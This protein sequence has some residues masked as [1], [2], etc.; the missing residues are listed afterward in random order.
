[1]D[2]G[3]EAWEILGCINGGG[4]RGADSDRTKRNGLKLKEVRF[5]LDVKRKFSTWRVV[6]HWYGLP[7]ES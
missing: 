7:R 1:M 3:Q 4:S 6:R 2:L 5:R